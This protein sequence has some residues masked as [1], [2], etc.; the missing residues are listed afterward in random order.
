MPDGQES[1]SLPRHV[2][3]SARPCRLTACWALSR[4]PYACILLAPYACILLA[5]QGP[6]R[7]ESPGAWCRRLVAWWR[8]PVYRLLPSLSLGA[9]SVLFILCPLHRFAL[10]S[11]SR[12]V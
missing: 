4:A 8:L 6:D 7:S 9:V 2:S 12:Q 11:S 1:S 3:T 5:P 10:S